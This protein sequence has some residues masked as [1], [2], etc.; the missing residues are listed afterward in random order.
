MSI[1]RRKKKCGLHYGPR[2]FSS[3]GK[4]RSGSGALLR[5]FVLLGHLNYLRSTHEAVYLVWIRSCLAAF[6]DFCCQHFISLATKT[7]EFVGGQYSWLHNGPIS[8]VHTRQ[9]WL[10][11]QYRLI[12][13]SRT[14]NI[15][16]MVSQCCNQRN[17]MSE[18][19]FLKP[20]LLIE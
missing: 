11:F 1:S 9:H 7:Q 18:D 15:T 14:Q 20:I 3:I 6:Q 16:S 13:H 4:L 17:C 2:R 8:S 10:P 5:G 12:I 19:Y